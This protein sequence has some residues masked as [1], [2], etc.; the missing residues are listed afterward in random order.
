MVKYAVFS[1]VHGNYK[2]LEAVLKYIGNQNVD[3]IIALGDYVT[4]G[5]YP[6]RTLELL[7]EMLGRYNC[8]MIRGN[9]EEY[10]LDNIDNR[11]GWKPSSANGT[12]YYT[13]QHVSEADMAFFASLPSEREV[14][15]EGCP[16]LYICHGTPGRVRGNV[17]EEA[18]LKE[19]VLEEL[20]FSYL[21]GG[22]SHHQETDHRLGKT[23]I[24]PGSLGF[25]VDGMGRRAQFA[26]L[27]GS[28]RGWE[29]ELLSIPYDVDGYLA[30][31]AESGV[32]EVGMT[33]NRAV[34]KSL[35]TGINYFYRCIVAMEAEAKRQGV[36][37]IAQMPEE[38]WRRLEQRF[39]L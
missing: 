18:G 34:K 38:A 6:E 20:K 1:D 27:T 25:A 23:Y 31:F 10:L 9:R 4:D 16:A 39:E 3:G 11:E 15:I 17:Y 30:A 32:D 19:K 21:L 12:L 2:A 33:L 22:H 35:V 13:M 14:R 36:P 26:L 7:H 5:P 24:N 29:T 37:S 8:C 28:G